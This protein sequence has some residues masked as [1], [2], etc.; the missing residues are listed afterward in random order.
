MKHIINKKIVTAV[1]IAIVATSPG[2]LF[3][4]NTNAPVAQAP[5][6]NIGNQASAWLGVTLDRV[7]SSLGSQ[8]SEI[9]PKGQGV[10]VRS[11]SK[12]SPAE[13]AGIKIN[14]VLLSADDQKLY[15]AAQ[16]SGLIRSVKPD[17]KVNF[18]LVTQG[19]IK[20]ITVTLGKR[21]NNS[22]MQSP[23]S[24][25]N[26]FT[27]MPS[28]ISPQFAPLAPNGSALSGKTSQ[29]KVFGS[30][31]SVQV[32]TLPDGRYHA[33]VSYKNK[34]DESKQFSFEGKREEIIEQ[35]KKHKELPDDKKRSLINALNMNLGVMGIPSVGSLFNHPFFNQPFFTG[36]QQGSLLNSPFFQINPF[37]DHFFQDNF[38]RG[39]FD[40]GFPRLKIAPKL[41][42]PNYQGGGQENEII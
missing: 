22:W 31:E 34:A 18:K 42:N 24:A 21:V 12:D 3:A 14:D 30:F 39:L 15:S 28:W 10:L 19:K 36:S 4:E 27:N 2:L 35:I 11:V 5:A 20:Q 6:A 8:L 7:P 41:L 26:S 40:P 16:L 33:E 38:P 29:A 17:S 37:N 1:A 32:R 25:N 9:I 13:K 23:L